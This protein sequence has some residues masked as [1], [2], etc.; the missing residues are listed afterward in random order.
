MEYGIDSNSTDTIPI[1]FITN[2]HT[3]KHFEHCMAE[4]LVRLKNYGTLVVNSLEA[5][6][7][8]YVVAILHSAINITRDDTGKELSMRPEYEVIGEESSGRVDYAIK[9]SDAYPHFFYMLY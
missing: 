9:V 5:M 2:P 6:C 4:I 3:D 7:N 1:F 8:E